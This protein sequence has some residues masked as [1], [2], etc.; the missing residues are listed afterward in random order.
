M[1]KIL[2]VLAFFIMNNVIAQQ[3]LFDTKIIYKLSFIPDSNHT[4]RIK[5][6]YFELLLNKEYSLFRS[7]NKGKN[8]SVDYAEIENIKNIN[9]FGGQHEYKRP[10]STNFKYNIFFK[11][12][13]LLYYEAIPHDKNYLYKESIIPIRSKWVLDSTTQ[14]ISGYKCQLAHLHYGGRN[15]SAWF[16]QDIPVVEGPYKFK[17]LPGLIIKI[18]DDRQFWSFELVGIISDK[19]DAVVMP[20]ASDKIQEVNKKEFYDTKMYLLKNWFEIKK[21]QHNNMGYS[22]KDAENKARKD[23]HDKVKADNNWIE[24][25]P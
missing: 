7:I 1:K 22:D 9:S 14:I 21:L 23:Y 12:E 8:D 24:L 3:H 2:I 20:S 15:W 17:E 11:N 18:E 5:E 10:L 4:D 13:E 19:Y 16:T 6:E 25:Y